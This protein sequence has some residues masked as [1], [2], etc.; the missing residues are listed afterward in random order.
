MKIY[1]SENDGVIGE[2]LYQTVEFTQKEF[3][4]KGIGVISQ[5][6]VRQYLIEE[7]PDLKIKKLGSFKFDSQ[8]NTV[9]VR[10]ATVNKIVPAALLNPG[11]DELKD[12]YDRTKKRYDALVIAV[13]KDA[14]KFS[15][16]LVENEE[17]KKQ[18]AALAECAGIDISPEAPDVQ[19]VIKDDKDQKPTEEAIDEMLEDAADLADAKEAIG[20]G[21]N[22]VLTQ[23]MIE[24]ACD[25]AE[26]VGPDGPFSESAPTA[27]ELSEAAQEMIKNA[28]DEGRETL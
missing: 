18:N 9:T 17:L 21:S 5:V 22:V 4:D 3:A 27:E 2:F 12:N 11:Y 13:A 6:A 14:Q 15:D 23:D 24:R 16:L 10:I 20:S 19:I 25:Q 28:E 1:Q 8:T 7:R 26:V